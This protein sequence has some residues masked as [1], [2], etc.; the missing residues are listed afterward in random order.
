[1]RKKVSIRREVAYLHM[2]LPLKHNENQLSWLDSLKP[3]E[4]KA[5]PQKRKI[6]YKNQQYP[7]ERL[8]L[9]QANENV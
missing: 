2:P 8:F 1:M 4:T 7:V 3:E 5:A 6:K 9:K